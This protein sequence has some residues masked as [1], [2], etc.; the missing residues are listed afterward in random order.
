[1]IA[2]EVF[3]IQGPLREP[4][5]I[6]E[7]IIT[8]LILEQ[9]LILWLRVKSKKSGE[10]KTLQ[11]KAYIWLF[12]G[13]GFMW[14]FIIISDFHIYNSYFG[15][16]FLNLGFIIQALCLLVFFMTMEKYKIY[17]KKY[18]FTKLSVLVLL[19]NIIV[20]IVDLY[21]AV[22]TISIFTIIFVI[23]FTIY[24]KE[25]NSNIYVKREY[26]N[27][28]LEILKFYFGT[29]IIAIGYQLT[30]RYIVKIYGLN[31][32]I[33][34]DLLQL[35]GFF[36][37]AWSIISVPSFTEYNWRDK[38]ENIFIIHKSGLL[39][40]EKKFKE[41]SNPLDGSFISA[42][43]TISQMM[44]ERTIYK[45]GTS[46]IEK[47]GKII[48]IQSGKY[49]NGILICDEKL[50]SIQILL[51]KLVERI[52]TVYLNVLKDWKG[53]LNIFLSIENIIKE[54]FF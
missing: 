31:Y 11:E 1:M 20:F 32:R 46:I 26:S 23:F 8:F 9:A 49:V 52:E 4:L 15:T 22:Y 30:T 51:N 41:K 19:F 16:I 7:G 18:L 2:Q 36:L 25:L 50:E 53:N 10:L 21:I 47:E 42:I 34:G 29:I 40:Y 39:I 28:K 43:L 44:L 24:F 3:P 6:L 5:L 37:L 13:Y 45:D 48:I 35:I 12:C 38:V 33:F 17:I 14:I 27:L 54:I